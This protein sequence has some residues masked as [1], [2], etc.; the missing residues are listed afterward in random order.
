MKDYKWGRR[1][2]FESQNNCN[3]SPLQ[4][5]LHCKPLQLDYIFAKTQ[6]VTLKKLGHQYEI[7]LIVLC[8][9]NG[10]LPHLQMVVTVMGFVKDFHYRFSNI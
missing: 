9:R 7:Q 2:T 1:W 4:I 8:Y 6:N 5:P 10:L 3:G